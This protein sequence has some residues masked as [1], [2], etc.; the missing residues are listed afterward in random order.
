M[1]KEINAN[2]KYPR[3][4][5]I[6]IASSAKEKVVFLRYWLAVTIDSVN[7]GS[8]SSMTPAHL[9]ALVNQAEKIIYG[10]RNGG[11]RVD[12]HSLE[13]SRSAHIYH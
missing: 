1:T 9:Q 2:A 13:L 3:A 4:S 8:R 11:G 7:L 10:V 12:M 5:S 6:W